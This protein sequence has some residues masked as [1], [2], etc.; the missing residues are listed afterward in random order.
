M[1]DDLIV[2]GGGIHGAATALEATLRGHAVRLIEQFDHLA[3]G[4]SSRSS[5]LVHGGLRYLEQHQWALVRESLTARRRLLALAPE[6]VEL[7]D[8]HIP[9][10]RHS[11]RSPG[12]IGL[13][14][15]LYAVLGG[16]DAAARFTRLP[17]R[18]WER[19]DGLATR[20]L[21]AVFRYHDG[22]TDDHALTRALMYAACR[23]GAELQLEE[24]V[25]R[26]VLHRQG[27][28]VVTEKGSYS[29]HA[30]VNAAG[31][32]VGSVLAAVTPIQKAPPIE[33]VAGSHLVVAGRLSQG[34]YYV[35]AP[36]DGRAVFLVPWASGVMIGTTERR[37]EGD[38]SRVV[39]TPAEM[40]Y[41][42]ETAAAHFDPRHVDVSQILGQFAGL[43]VLPRGEGDPFAR[44][45]DTRLLLDR[46]EPPRLVS[47]LG[48][49]LTTHYPTAQR[50]LD[51]LA[52]ALPQRR[53][54]ELASIDP[55]PESFAGGP[56]RPW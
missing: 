21:R 20:E 12:L 35:E 55:A 54:R 22:R 1:T 18:H 14:L 36:A 30:V 27:V 41:L 23:H 17:R 47:I 45:R 28:D 32:W 34:A 49:K 39:P 5:K 6:L 38:P 2:I 26:I 16:L 9:V 43:R 33:L 15:S 48:G 46:H 37:F 56:L 50:V 10:Y 44:A 3:Q 13:G 40:D 42:R 52:P 7:I 24:P 25:R 51:A 8:F 4:T 53:H 11:R 31:P 29:A 19:L